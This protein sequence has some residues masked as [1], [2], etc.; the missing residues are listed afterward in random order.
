MGSVGHSMNRGL[1]SAIV[2]LL[3]AGGC[4][5]P[6]ATT[7]EPSRAVGAGGHAAGPAVEDSAGPFTIQIVTARYGKLIVSTRPDATCRAR[8]TL[9]S[10]NVVLAGDFLVD[11]R[12]DADG[13]AIWVY[14][15][16][17]A[18]AG[19]GTG[20]YAVNCTSG[21]HSVDA[22]ADFAIP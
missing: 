10:G 20:R 19:S 21:G 9:P 18:G 2:V 8:A 14:R 4:A 7:P 11:Q 16:P 13:Q 3:L 15:T 22:T 6:G 5:A 17:V 1:G 12:P